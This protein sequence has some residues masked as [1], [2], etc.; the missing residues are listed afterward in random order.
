MFAGKVRT[1][2]HGISTSAA[3][4]PCCPAFFG[5]SSRDSINDFL[6]EKRISDLMMLCWAYIMFL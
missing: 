1:D 6:L 2:P 4:Q 5:N 3:Y